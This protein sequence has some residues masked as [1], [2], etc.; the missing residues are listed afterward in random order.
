MQ[1]FFKQNGFTYIEL[2]IVIVLFGI[3]AKM[4]ATMLQQGFD[5]Y[6]KAR[7]VTDADWQGRVAMERMTRDIRM[8]R[9]PAAITTNGGSNLVFTD[10]DGNSIDYGLSGTTLQRSGID[11]AEGVN[12]L[13]FTYYDKD[14]TSGATGTAIRYIKVSL[15]IT[16]NNTDYT[17]TTALYPR[18]LP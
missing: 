13:T 5:A 2:V 8:I 4:S 1:H 11:L 12:S 3:L 9:S 17:L 7:Y 15:N 10:T 14:G 6:L 18:N 16:Q